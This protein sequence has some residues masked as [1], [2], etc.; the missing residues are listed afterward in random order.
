MAARRRIVQAANR[1]RLAR[2]RYVRS[3]VWR[4]V[5][6]P[7]LLTMRQLQQ[8]VAIIRHHG[9]VDDAT[10]AAAGFRSRRLAPLFE[11]PRKPLKEAA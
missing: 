11:R 1:V 10:L 2:S 5:E 7:K 9:V 3:L 6:S 8:A 4:E